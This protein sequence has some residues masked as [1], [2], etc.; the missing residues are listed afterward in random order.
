MTTTPAAAQGG[1]RD[2]IFYSIFLGAPLSP[3]AADLPRLY[4]SLQVN[5]PQ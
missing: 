2:Q 5:A 1:G 3:A 4:S